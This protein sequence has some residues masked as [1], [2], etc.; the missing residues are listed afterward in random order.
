MFVPV[1]PPFGTDPTVF[2]VEIALVKLGNEP[3]AAEYQ[4]ADWA[5]RRVTVVPAVWE[6]W[7]LPPGTG[8]WGDGWP[9]GEYMAW[10]K[11]TTPDELAVMKSGRVRIGETTP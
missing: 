5:T 3:A 7:M 9:D 8:T 11:V 10:V 6:A 2:P 4:P 1:W